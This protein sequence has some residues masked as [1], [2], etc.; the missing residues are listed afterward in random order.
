MFRAFINTVAV[1]I[2]PQRTPAVGKIELS[3]VIKHLQ[4]AEGRDHHK[5]AKHEADLGE[6]QALSGHREGRAG[7][8]DGCSRSWSI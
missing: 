8:K 7:F 3:G 4:V 1:G 2:R 5:T 6:N